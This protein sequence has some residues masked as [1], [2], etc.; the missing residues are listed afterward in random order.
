[1]LFG[2]THAPL[3]ESAR[4]GRGGS[5][6]SQGRLRSPFMRV[7]FLKGWEGR[8]PRPSWPPPLG[9]P[10]VE[11]SRGDTASCQAPPQPLCAAFPLGFHV[12]SSG[13]S[14]RPELPSLLPP[15]GCGPL[16]RCRQPEKG[17]CHF[18]GNKSLFSNSVKRNCF[19]LRPLMT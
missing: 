1:M 17:R 19:Y 6:N 15:C 18:H 14:G 2:G 13:G 7:L 10:F 3:Y 12:G 11:P 9:A 5:F 4:K 8:P 16:L